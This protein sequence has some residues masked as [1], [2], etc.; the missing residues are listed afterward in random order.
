MTDAMQPFTTEQPGEYPLLIDGDGP[1]QAGH[2][3]G[4]PRKRLSVA[5]NC[6]FDEACAGG[7][8]GAKE[9]VNVLHSAVE[10]STDGV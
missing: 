3:I 8:I 10:C 5:L 4:D 2:G 1:R 7:L 9:R 6:V